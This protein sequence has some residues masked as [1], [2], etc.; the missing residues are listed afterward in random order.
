MMFFEH[1]RFPR[2]EEGR[3][4]GGCDGAAFF[5]AIEEYEYEQP[6][7]LPLPSA[8]ESLPRNLLGAASWQR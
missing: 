3:G 4:E 8:A 6:R 2:R 5:P 1:F 7:K